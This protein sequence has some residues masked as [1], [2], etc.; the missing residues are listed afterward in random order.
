MTLAR[1]GVFSGSVNELQRV[2]VNTNYC[3]CYCYCYCTPAAVSPIA[4]S[5]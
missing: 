2:D 1:S 5:I 3:Y 4:R